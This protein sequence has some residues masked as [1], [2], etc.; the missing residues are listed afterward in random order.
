MSIPTNA[1]SQ[2]RKKRYLLIAARLLGLVAGLSLWLYV[3]GTW[4][5][6][7]THNPATPAE[8]TVTQLYRTPQ[9]DSQIGC[10]ILV[11]APAT[12]VWTVI[13]A[14]ASHPRLLPYVNELE[15]QPQESDR[16][17]LTGVAHSRVWGD[18]PFAMQVNQRTEA[19]GVHSASWDEPGW[20]L[21]VNRRGWTVTAAGPRQALVVLSLQWETRG[22]PSFFL[23][24][25]LLDRLPKM[26]HS[27]RDEMCR[28][29]EMP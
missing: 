29:E 4:A 14:Y 26:P 11:D 2:Q 5:D 24:N 9:G 23:R 19:D 17:F 7:V 3:R 10:A 25:L 1:P 20:A 22:Y 16:V 13:R 12:K 28:R 18:W 8:G 6:P 27:L 21:A 15:V